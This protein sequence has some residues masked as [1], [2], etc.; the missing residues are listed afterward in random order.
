MTK[1]DERL[2]KSLRRREVVQ[3]SSIATYLV[4][5]RVMIGS[6]TGIAGLMGGIIGFFLKRIKDRRDNLRL[7]IE[8]LENY[9]QKSR[10]FGVRAAAV[11]DL[12][13]VWEAK[14]PESKQAKSL[15]IEAYTLYH[16]IYSQHRVGNFP[17]KS[18]D[19]AKEE[20][21][22]FVSY[23]Y[24]QSNLLVAD[25]IDKDFGRFMRGLKAKRRRA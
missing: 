11:P 14:L 5:N 13:K 17:P 16:G 1:T 3:D 23:G 12:G 2:I 18:W 7:T 19:A 10:E 8:A 24:I 15:M 21:Q 6:V 4:E 25:Q 22:D 20:M 9:Y